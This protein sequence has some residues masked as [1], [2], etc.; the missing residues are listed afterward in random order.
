MSARSGDGLAR[1]RQALD[2]HGIT[3]RG[4]AARCPAH[5]D[6]RATLS[7]RQGEK[8][9]LVKCH[10][11]CALDAILE[12]LGLSAAD[13]FDDPAEPR[14]GYEVTATYTYAGE[15][16]EPLFYVERRSPKDFR[17]YRVVNGARVWNLAGVERVPYRLPELLGAASAG[18][19]VYVT[20]GE[21]D[22][23]AIRAAG[24]TATTNPGG[25]GKWRAEYAD[26]FAGAGRVIVVADRDEPGRAHAGQV[27][28][29]L[30]PVVPEVEIAEAAKGKDAGDHLAAGL[31]LDEF[32]PV[33]PANKASKANKVADLRERREQS[34]EQSAN[35][36]W[37]DLDPAAYYG[38]AGELA[39]DA[40]PHTEA[41][42]AGVLVTFLAGAGCYLVDGRSHAGFPHVWIGDTEH[43]PRIFPLLAGP[44][45]D[46]RKGTADAIVRRVL[47]AADRAFLHGH[48][49]SGLTSGSGLIEAVRDPSDDDVPAKLR[50]PGVEDKR[51]L[52]VEHEFS[53]TLRRAGR[54]GNDLAERLREAWDGR[55]LSS[56]A[57]SVNRLQAT[58][59]HI[60]VIGHIAPEELRARYRESTDVVGGT[61][62]RLMPT[63]VR[64][65]R[66]LPA[67]GGV[68]GSII[69]AAAKKLAGLREHA[70]TA[71]R[72][73]RDDEAETLWRDS[74][75]DEL[76]PD[77]VPEGYVARM[78]A[79]AAP[80][81]MRLALIYCL[82]DGAP[83]ITVAHLGAAMAVWRYSLASVRYI[84]GDAGD[85]DLDRLA[86][87]VRAAGRDGLTGRQQHDLF[88]RHKTAAQ[89]ADLAGRLTALDGYE[90]ATEETSG[91]PSGRLI[92]AG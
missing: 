68:P 35:K 34:C 11:G 39:R 1:F 38:L 78:V 87:A 82:L 48:V 10:A 31:G 89:L 49:V 62:N 6:G 21:K 52:V 67:G 63:L 26:W 24:A 3:Y 45:A 76:T 30:R 40:A 27:A 65:S 71:L 18:G 83:A 59:A 66:R 55:P 90:S 80:Q 9:A 70:R 42:P 74:L 22:A 43:P 56:M 64:R 58:G 72:Y 79:R 75:Y 16:G 54:D 47:D 4:G 17:Q 88:G 81:V 14:Q 61:A 57:R 85:P 84:F 86:E 33:I 5:D 91:R 53:G 77:G 13:L 92:W 25:A 44:T 20:E 2:D 50:H 15:Y 19:T 73:C 29:S 7:F 51:L 28:A 32:R 36:A 41:D 37:P 60:V 8:A 46:G 23:D 12:A 69:E